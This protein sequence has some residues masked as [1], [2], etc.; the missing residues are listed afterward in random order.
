MMC[1]LLITNCEKCL[2]SPSYGLFIFAVVFY[3]LGHSTSTEQDT[4]RRTTLNLHPL[5]FICRLY[6]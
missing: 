2:L 5:L 4:T 3:Q 6:R 1:V